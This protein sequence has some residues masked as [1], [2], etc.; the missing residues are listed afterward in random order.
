MRRFQTVSNQTASNPTAS[1]RSTPTLRLALGATAA[2]LLAMSAWTASAV[3][4]EPGEGVRA[5]TLADALEGGWR[6]DDERARDRWRH[7]R[8]TLEFFGLAPGMTVVEISPGRGWYTKILAPYVNR[9]GGTFIAAGFDPKDESAYAKRG[10]EYFQ[11]HF[12]EKPDVYGAIE[13][14]WIGKGSPGVAPDGSADLIL[15]FRNVHNWVPS[16]WADE[17]FADMFRALRPGGV[18]GVVDH[19]LPDDREADEKLRGG[20]IHEQTVVEIAEKAGFVLEG[21]SPI[22]RN[23]KDT[24]DHPFGVWTLPP[25]ARTAAFGKPDDPSFDRA[26]YD[27]IGESDRFT[28]RFRKPATAGPGAK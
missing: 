16:G 3:H 13:V 24:A 18:L 27:A 25:V 17:A 6:D 22:N 26:K 5:F 2:A 1:N 28:L 4:H 23:E 9:T 14:T 15:T 20:Y 8:A 10:R 7:P 11:E 21:S 19:R 12:V